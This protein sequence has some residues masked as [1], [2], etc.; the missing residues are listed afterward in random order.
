MSVQSTGVSITGTGVYPLVKDPDENFILLSLYPAT[1]ANGGTGAYAG[2]TFTVKASP[3][4]SNYSDILVITTASGSPVTGSTTISP[5]DSTDYTWQIPNMVGFRFLEINVTA[6]G[7]GSPTFTIYTFNTPTPP[8]INSIS[9]T[10][11][12]TNITASGTLAVAGASTFGAEASPL[13]NDGAALG[14]G[15]HAWSDLFL[16]SG[17]VLNYN[18]GNVV[19][20]HSAGILTMGTGELRI[21]TAGT[22]AASVPTLGST[23]TLT[24]KTL[25]APVINGATSASGNFDLS[26]ST[27]TFLTSTG[28]NT[29]GGNVLAS[30]GVRVSTNGATAITTTRAVTS[31]DSLGVFT[32]AQ[33][34]AY[35]ITVATPAAAGERYLFQLVSPGA[36]D[37]SLVATGCT[38]EGTITIDAATIPATGS[39]LKYA[40]GAA[41][42]G[43]NIELISTSTTK[44]L[45]RAIGSGAGG[46]TIS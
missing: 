21:T 20:T 35:T 38:F 40:S 19:V 32:V 25:T 4:G 14:D 30:K 5:S 37:V 27:G 28:V 41:I 8:F 3:D 10:G 36:F 7:S 13:A 22:N 2:L 31:S 17:A 45:V 26:G 24:N 34:S 44:F 39:T 23:N 29:L 46:I 12:F 6:Y 1:V 42:L 11:T 43:D 9:T 33:S 16:A 15:S 18:N